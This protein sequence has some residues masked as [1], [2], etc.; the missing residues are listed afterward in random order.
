MPPLGP[1]VSVRGDVNAGTVRARIRTIPAPADAR[2]EAERRR[3][4]SPGAPFGL[5]STI[6]GISTESGDT[7]SK[8]FAGNRLQATKLKVSGPLP[9]KTSNL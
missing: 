7:L 9:N 1:G 4:A 8:S 2:R 5:S 6:S 3:G